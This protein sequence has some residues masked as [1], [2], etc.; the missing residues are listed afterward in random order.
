MKLST[1]ISEDSVC[2]IRSG[3]GLELKFYIRKLLKI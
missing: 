2:C 1:I 3:R